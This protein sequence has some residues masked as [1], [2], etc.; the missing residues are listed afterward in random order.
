MFTILLLSGSSYALDSDAVK[1]DFVIYSSFTGNSV[2]DAILNGS[3]SAI[4]ETCFRAGSV[5]PVE[6]IYKKAAI[7]KSDGKD[8]AD[9]YRNSANLLKADLLSVLSVTNEGGDYILTAAFIPLTGRYRDLKCELTVRSSI[10]ENIPLKAAREFAS[11]LNKRKRASR[12]VNVHEDGTAQIDSGQWHGLNP[13]FYSTD[14]GRVEVKTVSRFTSVVSG[15]NLSQGKELNLGVTADLNGY[16]GELNYRIR[17]NTVR[18]YGTD[19]HLNK[20]DGSVKESIQGTCVINM[21]ASFCL[22]GYGSFMSLEYMGIEKGKVDYPAVAITALLTTA[23]LGLVPYMTDFNAN[24]L[25]WKDDRDRT[26]RERRLNYYLWGTLPLTFTSSFYSQLAYNYQIKN[27]LPPLFTDHDRSASLLSVFVPGAGLFYKGY[28]WPAWG[29][30]IGE[31]SMA[32][33]A[34]YTDD[35]DLRIRLIAALAGTKCLEVLISYIIPPSYN[36][37]NR[38]ISSTGD[39][40][41]S[42][43]INRSQNGG[44]ELSVAVSFRY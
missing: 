23:H 42:F 17:E 21:G 9:L 40:D 37:F 11:L 4:I 18:A 38:E 30:Y 28:R 8:R 10:A 1:G 19:E 25:P 39:P 32:G 33:Y 43:W 12:V 34:V 44:S 2:F 22:P 24:F 13:G 20:R 6:Y 15:E 3:E 5:I 35:R 27:M 36:F 14:S 41:F 29:V 16:I 7:D 26:S 31:I